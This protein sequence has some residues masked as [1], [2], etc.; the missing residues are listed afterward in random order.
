MRK[1][2]AAEDD[3]K[4]FKPGM[5]VE[6]S[7]IY[8]VFHALHRITHQVTLVAGRHF[9]YCARCRDKVRFELARAVNDATAQKSPV[10]HVVGV[11]LP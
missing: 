10:L 5:V 6:Q 9:P 8:E 3:K 11:F 1:A 4:R 2:A 7:G